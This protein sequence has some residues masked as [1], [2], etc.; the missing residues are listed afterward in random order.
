MEEGPK[1]KTISL[2]EPSLFHRV[3]NDLST[4]YLPRD[5]TRPRAEENQ[6]TVSSEPDTEE[7]GKGQHFYYFRKYNHFSLKS[8]LC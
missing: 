6:S 2:M 5:I 3:D 1:A 7:R 4:G 8:Y